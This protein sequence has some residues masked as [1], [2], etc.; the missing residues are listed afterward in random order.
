[1]TELDLRGVRG[2][3]I[4]VHMGMQFALTQFLDM[5]FGFATG[6]NSLSGGFTVK[7]KPVELDYSY[8]SHSVLPGTHHVS[9]RGFFVG[10]KAK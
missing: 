8:S 3:D 1:L 9:V 2:E 5:R 7:M 10:T 6:P 4:E